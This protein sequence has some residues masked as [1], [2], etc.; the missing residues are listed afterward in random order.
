M[1]LDK[2]L[3]KPHQEVDHFENLDILTAAGI[4]VHQVEVARRLMAI[5]NYLNRS[6]SPSLIRI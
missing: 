1:M 2:I 5:T 4:S 6:L 3:Q